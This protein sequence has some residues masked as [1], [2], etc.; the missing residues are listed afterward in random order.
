M[1]AWLIVI[2]I[3]WLVSAGLIWL[4][5]YKAG[6]INE[7]YDRDAAAYIDRLMRHA[8]S[9]GLENL[10]DDTRPAWL[11]RELL[12]SRTKAA[13]AL[14]RTDSDPVSGEQASLSR[15]FDDPR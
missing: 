4:F 14:R 1:N 13:R 6:K 11:E 8:E 9:R 5:T 7:R 3:I 15:R 12:T 10:I 2:G